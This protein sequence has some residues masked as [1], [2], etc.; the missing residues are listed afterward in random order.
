[1][2]AKRVAI[3]VF[4]AGCLAIV[5]GLLGICTTKLRKTGCVCCY[6]MWNFI[7]MVLFTAISCVI[8]ALYFIKPQT[9][10]AFCNDEIKEEDVPSF[11]W[12]YVEE[13]SDATKKI[14]SDLD[15]SVNRFMCT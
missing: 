9:V 8:L 7:I 1:M 6:G 4:S 11:V 3:V 10:D 5:Y 15:L 13:A 2:T 12:P 14:D